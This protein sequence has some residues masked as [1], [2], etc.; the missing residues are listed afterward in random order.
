MPDELAEEPE[1]NESS[2]L[3]KVQVFDRKANTFLEEVEN[4][5]GRGVQRENYT[6]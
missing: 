1:E 5:I 3:R 2:L 4:Q 6:P